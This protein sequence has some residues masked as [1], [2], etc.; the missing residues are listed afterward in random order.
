MNLSVEEFPSSEYHLHRTVQAAFN[1][2]KTKRNLLYILYLYAAQCTLSTMLIKTN[3]LMLYKAK[4]A[5][6]SENSTKHSKQSDHH[7]EFLNVNLGSVSSPLCVCETR[8]RY[9]VNTT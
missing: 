3:Q 6:C 4:V 7:V 5:V 1:L 2:L 8:R 9:V